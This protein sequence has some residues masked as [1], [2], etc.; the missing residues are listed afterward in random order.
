VEDLR[1]PPSA[2]G[3]SLR[4]LL[5]ELAARGVGR[6][7]FEGG[8]QLAR[9]LLELGLVD[10]FHRFTSETP[11]LGKPVDLDVSSLPHLRAQV[12]F[13]DGRWDVLARR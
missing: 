13:K 4:H 11:A 3:C 7:L 5:H 9:G 10:E 6:V 1:L 8:G 2:N 12:S